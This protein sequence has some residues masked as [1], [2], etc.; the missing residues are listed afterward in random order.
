MNH[1]GTEIRNKRKQMGLTQHDVAGQF[2]S[3]AKL[4]NIE[5]GKKR[6]DPETWEYLKEKLGLSDE[7]I[8]K[9]ESIEE[10]QFILEQAETY[11][12]TGII[13]KAKE[14]YEE[15][16]RLTPKLMLFDQTARAF[17]ELGFIAMEEKDY[18][19][20][21][22]HLEKAY[23]YY[24]R[25]KDSEN[26]VECKV[27][28]GAIYFRQEKLTKSLQVFQQ[29]LKEIPE[30]RQYLK[31]PI[32]Y[33]MA[34]VYYALKNM[35]RANLCCE[36]ALKYLEETGSHTDYL[37]STLILQAI[38]FKKVKMYLLAREK[39]ERAKNLAIRNNKPLFMA[40]CWHNLGNV[41]MEIKNYKSA[42]QHFQLS[43]EVKEQINDIVGMIRTK[44]YM[45]ELYLEMGDIELAK[46]TGDEALSMS[47]KYN[48]KSAEIV[49]L[50]A[51]SKIHLA[52]ND[53][54]RF[55]DVTFKAIT[56]ADELS[57]DIKKIE[58]YENMSRYF[59][60]RDKQRCLEMLYKA[61]TVKLQMEAQEEK[62][63][64]GSII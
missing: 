63:P 33:N 12:K 23:D 36:K 2:M 27:K 64:A 57:Y 13:H 58:L 34:S 45:A 4:S 53:E 14:K 50:G 1:I 30:D 25:I 41:E 18:K 5:N 40:K 61:F 17:K 29:V 31:G 7:L 54:T 44:A 48:S 28:I 3:I 22:S 19:Q 59:Y 43:L 51:L 15:A 47:R 37:I 10:T 6:P 26:A 11:Y 56:L 60:T 49:C 9:K 38:F 52:L 35:D 42:L 21:H 55:L 32:Y 46:K 39:L 20:A 24:R 8:H 62:D 16:I